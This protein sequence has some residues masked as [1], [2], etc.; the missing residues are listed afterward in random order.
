M[1]ALFSSATSRSPGPHANRL[2]KTA[3]MIAGYAWACSNYRSY[4]RPAD[5]KLSA[6][7]PAYLRLGITLDG[8]ARRYEQFCRR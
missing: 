3:G 7:H 5:D 4:T 2:P 8:Y 6:W 1:T